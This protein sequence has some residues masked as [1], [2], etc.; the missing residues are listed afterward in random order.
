M[1]FFFKNT[2]LS[3]CYSVLEKKLSKNRLVLVKKHTHLHLIAPFHVITRN[4]FV[5][6]IRMVVVVFDFLVVVVLQGFAAVAVSL[7]YF[8][9]LDVLLQFHLEIVGDFGVHLLSP[10]TIPPVALIVAYVAEVEKV[11]AYDPV[12]EKVVAYDPVIEKVVAHDPVVEKV[13][14]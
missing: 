14:A 10:P 12:V 6:L 5:S 13:V 9:V 1:I 11:V 4:V 3:L 2:I 7:V 8:P